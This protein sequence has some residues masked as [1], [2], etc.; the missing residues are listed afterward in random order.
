[1]RR[2]AL[3]VCAC[4]IAMMTVARA[5]GPAPRPGSGQAPA[6]LATAPPVATRLPVR[7]VV[8]YKNGVGYFEHVGRVRGSQSVTIDFNTAQLNDVL[9][10]LTTLDLRDG[11]IADVSFNSEA[12]L[13]QRL[14]ALTL[15]VGERT[16]LPELLGALRGARLEVRAGDRVI[17]GRLL[18][19]ERRP[20]RDEAPRDELTLV[21]DGG[22]IRSVELTPAVTVRLAERDSADQ[23]GAYLVLLASTRA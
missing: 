4:A 10:S 7:R 1:M 3:I 2:C 17:A 15:P 20:R 13:A 19:V 5:Q 9:Q 11:R 16:T 8:L 14:G 12:P 21:T 22:D 23:F 6:P 18:S